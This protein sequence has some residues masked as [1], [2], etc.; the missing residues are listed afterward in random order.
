MTI[1]QCLRELFPNDRRVEYSISNKKLYVTRRAR[2][3]LY[4][5]SLSGESFSC[6]FWISLFAIAFFGTIALLCIT[7][8]LWS[9][10]IFYGGIFIWIISSFSLF[11]ATTLPER[12]IV[13]GIILCIS[14][15][16]MLVCWQIQATHPE[17]FA[18]TSFPYLDF[19]F[20]FK[21]K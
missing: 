15:A 16:V 3:S 11:G 5:G 8:V 19:L 14:L 20:K 9:N 2:N 18:S 6:T 17:D 13:T 1:E 10:I 4:Y 21:F 12:L 7:N